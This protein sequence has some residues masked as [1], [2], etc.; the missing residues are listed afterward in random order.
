M[1]KFLLAVLILVMTVACAAEGAYGMI[2]AD[3]TLETVTAAFG[4]PAEKDEYLL[5]DD[6]LLSFWESGR[7]QAK[8]RDCENIAEVAAVTESSFDAVLKLKQGAP[9]DKVISELGEGNEIMLITLA[10][11]DNAG[12]RK[13]LAWK[14]ADGEVLEALFELDG[15][16]WVLFAITVI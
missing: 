5:C 15:G 11:E 3:A 4:A 7:L 14:H 12:V 9:V 10:D 2:A 1:K 6:T 8:I 16:E 13:V